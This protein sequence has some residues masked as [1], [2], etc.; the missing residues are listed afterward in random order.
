V[1]D[2]YLL[3]QC[4]TEAAGEVFSTML[5]MAIHFTGVT[6]GPD[7]AANGLISLIGITGDWAGAGIFCCSPALANK[8]CARM[9]GMELDPAKPAIDEEVMDVVAEVTNMIVGNIKNGLEPITGPL[10]ISVPTVIHGKNFHFRNQVGQDYANLSFTTEG[11]TFQVRV[12]LAPN[13]E[14]STGH[15]RVPILGMAHF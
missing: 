5:D 11:E 14:H 1:I 10:A 15:A 8:I 2:Q 3:I 6:A 4:A 13:M 9:L 12:S 7:D